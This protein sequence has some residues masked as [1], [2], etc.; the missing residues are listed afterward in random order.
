MVY[1][2]VDA[3]SFGSI[4]HN[5]GSNL[6]YG[7]AG[8][9]CTATEYKDAIR[10]MLEMMRPGMLA[11]GIAH[12]DPVLYRTDVATYWSKHLV[13]VCEALGDFVRV[14][15]AEKIS[16]MLDGFL[17]EGTDILRMTV[18]VCHEMGIATV[19]SYRMA[20]E[21]FY[22]MQ[23]AMSD[24]NREHP[25]LR[26]PGRQVL[27][28]VHV[29]VY[30]HL[31]DIFREMLANYEVDGIELNFRRMGIMISR[32]LENHPV[33][34]RLVHDV[35]RLLDDAAERRDCDRLVLGVRV[36]PMLEGPYVTKEFPGS[37][38]HQN[39]NPSCRD[40]GL[41]V[42]AWVRSGEIDYVAPMLFN[43]FL[44]GLPKTR[45]FVELTNGTKVAVYP[46]LFST[47]MWLYPAHGNHVPPGGKH[48]PPI[49]VD[50][51][52]RQ[53]RYKNELCDCALK[54]YEDGAD[55]IGTFNWM[56]HHQKGVVK[57][58]DRLGRTVGPGGKKVM[59]R[60]CSMLGSRTALQEY[61]G[62]DTALP[63]PGA[64]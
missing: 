47:P 32:P 18:D 23:G 8:D 54:L 9:G 31:L 39:E 2:K 43:T 1:R 17:A 50:D 33:L 63:E 56:G 55:G 25:H 48:E 51:N 46:T 36:S 5:D 35:R 19:P 22:H 57:D 24:F 13:E 10:T 45:E 20:A 37:H 61:R 3:R 38:Y 28:P 15:E 26:M 27:D 29:E 62:S 58:P 64:G 59:M 7:N 42:P 11:Q 12:P 53:V 52:E 41:D 49:G 60:V 6:Y 21:D 16:A 44:P 40:C 34:T 4:I 30:M 14:G